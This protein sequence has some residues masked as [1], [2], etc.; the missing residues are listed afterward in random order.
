MSGCSSG[1]DSDEDLRILAQVGDKKITVNEFIKRSEYTI[2]PSY[3]RDNNP[4]HKKIVLN[5][6]I[7]EKLLAIESGNNNELTKNSDFQAYLEGRK[8]QAMRQI[9]FY[10]EFYQKVDLSPEIVESEFKK[11]GRTFEISYFT[12]KDKKVADLISGTFQ[13]KEKSFE[14]VYQSLSGDTLLPTRE[15][16]WEDPEDGRIRGVLFENSP[17]KGD[18]VGPLNID[19]QQFIFIKIKGWTDRIAITENDIQTRQQ[20]VVEYLTHQEALTNYK[21]HVQRLMKNKR[22]EFYED[23]FKKIIHLVAPLYLD[24]AQKEQL[25]NSSFWQDNDKIEQI[26][27]LPENLDKISHH[28]FFSV[29]GRVWTVGKFRDYIKRHPLVF[30]K[31]AIK[32]NNF[33]EQFKLAVVDMVRDFYITEDAYKKNYDKSGIVRREVDIWQDHLL[34]VH[35]K[36]QYLQSVNISEMDQ[37]KIVDTY[38]TPYVNTLQQKYNNDI[39]INVEEF[40]NIE[41]TNIDLI[42]LKPDQPF[43]VVTPSFPLLTTNHRLDY[44][45]KM[46]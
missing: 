31:K 30:R 32:N 12:L 13:N 14:S 21:N 44:G 42:A 8:E 20:N 26:S 11:A 7:G 4:I 34:S 18:V 6:L 22:M 33:S 15:V 28:P 17:R 46:Q 27:K 23:T 25:F 39:K 37:I 29:D 43:P 10:D 9:Q 40:E 19:D 24:A 1:E 2:R 3:C 36:Y 38:M 35:Q 16:R 45:Q 41:L 5:S